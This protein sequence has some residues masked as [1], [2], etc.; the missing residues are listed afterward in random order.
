MND[1]DLATM[2][3]ETVELAAGELE[4]T[5][6]IAGPTFAITSLRHRGVELLLAPEELPPAYRLQG[7]LAGIALMHPWAG[8]LSE[9]RFRVG[10]G[11]VALPADDPVVSRSPSSGVPLHGLR[12]RGAWSLVTESASESGVAD[13]TRATAT[14]DFTRPALLAL[15]PFPHE[16]T[17]EV[18][19]RPG[20]LDLT[21]ELRPT[22]EVAVPVSFGWHPYLRLPGTPRAEWQVAWPAATHLLVDDRTLPTGAREDPAAATRFALGSRALDDSYDGIA[23][24]AALAVSD[25]ERELRCELREGFPAAQLF[26]P[27][28]ADVVSLE[29]MTAVPNALVSGEG[30]HVAHPGTTFTARVLLRVGDAPADEPVPAESARPEGGALRRALSRLGRRRRRD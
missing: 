26:A 7:A 22:G 18:V 11:D 27:L 1:L 8:R 16:L 29:P 10:D 30:L 9:D 17:I 21:V 14:L 12:T 19:L 6:S 23:D 24:G 13:G 2:A 25:R 5:L 28:D 3:D 15:F 4:A 20:T